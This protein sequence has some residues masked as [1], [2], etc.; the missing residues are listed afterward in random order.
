MPHSSTGPGLCWTASL[1]QPVKGRPLHQRPLLLWCFVMHLHFTAAIITYLL[2]VR[3]VAEQSACL[4]IECAIPAHTD[5]TLNC[6]PGPHH[7]RLKTFGT[8]TEDQ[9]CP[10]LVCIKRRQC[11]GARQQPHKV[12]NQK[13]ARFMG[14]NSLSIA[15]VDSPRSRIDQQSLQSTT[16]RYLGP[17][18]YC[19]TNHALGT[20][21]FTCSER[22][23]TPDLPRQ[24]SRVHT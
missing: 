22:Q 2:L 23:S 7:Q 21:S 24:A 19:S 1:K 10:P 6:H 12:C 11:V 16:I 5:F 13:M 3:R 14:C 15:G 9:D 20:V 17:M 8:S 18:V 4:H